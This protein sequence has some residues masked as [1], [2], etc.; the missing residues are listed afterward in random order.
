M[1]EDCVDFD[2]RDDPARAQNWKPFKKW[3]MIIVLALMT[4]LS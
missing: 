1:N 2:G 3:I 4:F